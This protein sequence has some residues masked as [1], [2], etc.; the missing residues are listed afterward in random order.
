MCL[1]VYL[2][3]VCVCI[4]VHHDTGAGAFQ[5]LSQCLGPLPAPVINHLWVGER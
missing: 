4:D 3:C 2:L 1:R 5:V